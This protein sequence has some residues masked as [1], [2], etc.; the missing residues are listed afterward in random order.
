MG[1]NFLWTLMGGQGAKKN[2]KI[3]FPTF[4]FQKFFTIFF[5]KFFFHEQRQALQLVLLN[6][7]IYCLL[8]LQ[9]NNKTMTVLFLGFERYCCKSLMSHMSHRNIAMIPLH[10]LTNYRL[11]D[12]FTPI[13]YLTFN[14]CFLC[15]F[16]MYNVK[17]LWEFCQ[18]LF[19]NQ[20]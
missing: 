14:C 1:W 12:H 3:Y 11:S 9:K 13:F 10:L 15:V 2:S 7:E 4:F 19:K 6:F 20:R 8:I 18:L 17:Q 16:L 5:S